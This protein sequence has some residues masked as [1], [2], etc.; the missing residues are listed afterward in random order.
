MKRSGFSIEKNQGISTIEFALILPILVFLI[1]AGFD[2][3]RLILAN[4]VIINM[5]REGANLSARTTRSPEA[6]I[7][8]LAE[9]ADLLDMQHQG[10]IY[11]TKLQGQE[12]GS[13]KILAQSSFRDG[14]TAL[15]SRIWPY[16][17]SW[18]SDGSCNLPSSL[19]TV[20][21]DLLLDKGEI[22]FAAEVIYEY[23]PLFANMFDDLNELHA[24]TLL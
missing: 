3:S 12:D 2:Y 10:M 7:I 14:D 21:L 16:C 5:A 19:P 23:Q 11:I 22:V 24:M 6:V 8:A 15:D 18:A 20:N 4:N 13:A 17:S 9:T 1:M